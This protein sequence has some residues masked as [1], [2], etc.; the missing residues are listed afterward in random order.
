MRQYI[1][2][3][4]LCCATTTFA[5][6]NVTS[7]KDFGGLST[8]QYQNSNVE[9][10]DAAQVAKYNYEYQIEKKGPHQDKKGDY[11]GNDLTPVIF[12]SM[13]NHGWEI[14]LLGIGGY[15]NDHITY[16]GGAGLGYEARKIGVSGK[17]ILQKGKENEAS[18]RKVGDFL[19]EEAIFQVYFKPVEWNNHHN[20]VRLGLAGTFRLSQFLDSD[21]MEW[22]GKIVNPDGT[23]TTKSTTRSD[24][25]I[26]EFTSGGNLFAEIYGHKRWSNL[27]WFIGASAGLQQ[28]ILLNSNK[29]YFEAQVYAG[30]SIRLFQNDS[31][32][33]AAMQKYGKTKAQ[34]DNMNDI[35]HYVPQYFTK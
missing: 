30:L 12:R 6:T 31:Y 20:G 11:V 24:L 3:A 8:E 2:A 26:R 13:D 17:F 23:T 9:F 33:T 25:D 18:D 1:F 35:E 19:Q 21:Q 27:G 14:Y 10:S 15:F 5:Q 32:N 29:F 34:V 22:S 16:G 4:M 28:D 7:D